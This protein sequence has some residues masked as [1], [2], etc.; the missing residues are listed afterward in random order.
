MA[1]NHAGFPNTT[2]FHTVNRQCSS[3]LQA[4]A[5]LAN[6]IRAGEIEV[7]LAGGVESMSRNYRATK[8]VPQDV[9]PRLRGS[10]VESARDCLMP[11]Y[12]SIVRMYVLLGISADDVWQGNY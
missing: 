2:T 8:G 12:V 4:V 1:L 5:H 9:S 7:G 6:A 10:E 3:S 11:M